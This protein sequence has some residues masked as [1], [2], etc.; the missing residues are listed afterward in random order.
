MRVQGLGEGFKGVLIFEFLIHR[1]GW[2][3]IFRKWAFSLEF[4]VL[5]S[6]FGV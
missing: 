5:G 3:F 6:G 2:N 1:S 4:S